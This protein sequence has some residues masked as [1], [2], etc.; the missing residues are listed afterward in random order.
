MALELEIKIKVSAHEP[1]RD[2]L[3]RVG[4]VLKSTVLEVNRLF[5]NTDGALRT[6]GEVLRLRTQRSIDGSSDKVRLTYK[7]PT[8]GGV[9]KSRQEH[10]VEVSDA[11]TMLAILTNLGY[12]DAFLFE[13]RRETWTLAGA[14]VEL[15]EVPH[16]GTFVEIEAATP[17][18]IDAICERLGLDPSDA[19]AQT[20]VGLLLS[21]DAVNAI[22][23]RQVRFE[24]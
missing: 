19:V 23:S 12:R 9:Y 2:A 6:R 22:I 7:G 20:Y 24:C 16:L 8:E 5:D 13:K 15:D 4:G 1:V 21:N 18:K 10:E 14:T 11:D 17:E 3:R